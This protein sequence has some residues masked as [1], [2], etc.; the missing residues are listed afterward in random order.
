MTIDEA[1]KRALPIAKVILP[2]NASKIETAILTAEVARMMQVDPDIIRKIWN[3]WKCP[4]ILLPFLAHAVSVDVWSNDWNEEQ[5]RKVIAASP[6]V[7]RLKG[8]RAAIDRALK[9]FDIDS[10]VIEWWEDDARRGTFRVE[11]LYYNGGPLFDLDL[12]QYAIDSVI[13]A[14]PKARV[15]TSR[16]VITARG[17]FYHSAYPKANFLRVAHPYQFIP[18]VVR[19]S[20][21]I[22]TTPTQFMSATA[23]PKG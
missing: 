12:Q 20:N 7:H 4:T 16:A 22:A 14:K 13:A 10:R 2:P 5:K 9:A 1:I 11:M 6:S 23:H 15:F 21:Y 8:T 18:P 17:N 3:P 19:A